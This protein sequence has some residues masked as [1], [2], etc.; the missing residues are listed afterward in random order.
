MTDPTTTPANVQAAR[1]SF[2]G[3]GLTEA[4]FDK[5]WALSS[6]LHAEIKE[7]GTFREA[8]TDFS[9]AFARGEKF[10][11]LRAEAVL[12][13]VFT[14]RYGQSMNQLRE[15]LKANLEGLPETAKARA[16]T[17]AES[18]EGM[19]K[20]GPTR[21][22]YQAYD[23]AAVTLSEELTITRD[24]AK[25]LM[26][27]AFKETHGRELGDHGKEIEAAY[28]KPVREAQ[29]AARKAED[30]ETHNRSRSVS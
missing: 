11:A 8:L 5:A 28:H 6:V 22:F 15:G 24:G 16:L 3:K 23:A 25:A 7:R 12:R 4:Q 18:I 20:E 14:G 13:D 19:I 9:H 29:I 21:P 10:D 2:N 26:R 30:L 27:E 1:Q 17:A